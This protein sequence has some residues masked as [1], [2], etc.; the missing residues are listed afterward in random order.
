MDTASL[1]LPCTYAPNCAARPATASEMV[2]PLIVGTTVEGTVTVKLL[3]AALPIFVLPLY[4]VTVTL[5]VPLVA[6]GIALI[7]DVGIA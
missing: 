5:A 3:L 4:V 6:L 1:L 2:T 7:Q